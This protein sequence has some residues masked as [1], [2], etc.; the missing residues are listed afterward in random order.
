VRVQELASL[1]R[2]G[3][4]TGARY[5]WM[6]GEADAY[7]EKAGGPLPGVDPGHRK[8]ARHVADRWRPFRSFA[9]AQL[10]VLGPWVPTPGDPE[11]LLQRST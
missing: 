9:Y 2:V 5:A 11:A 4:V 8:R 7:P 1:P 3:P 6:L 10:A